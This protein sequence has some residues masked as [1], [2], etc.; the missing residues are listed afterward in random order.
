METFYAFTKIAPAA[1]GSANS[2][3][4]SQVYSIAVV[5]TNKPNSESPDELRSDSCRRNVIAHTSTFAIELELI[6]KY[7]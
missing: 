1:Q 4:R 3:R 6:Q 2:T 5:I 7:G